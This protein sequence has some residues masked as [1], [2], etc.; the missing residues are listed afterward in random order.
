LLNHLEMIDVKPNDPHMPTQ[1]RSM[2][3][4]TMMM[5]T[6][7]YTQSYFNCLSY[8]SD[9]YTTCVST[10]HLFISVNWFPWKMKVCDKFNWPLIS[11]TWVFMCVFTKFS[12]SFIFVWRV[13]H[14]SKWPPLSFVFFLTKRQRIF[15][16]RLSN[17][18]TPPTNK[19]NQMESK[20]E[21]SRLRMH[22]GIF[23]HE[24]MR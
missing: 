23:A 21:K 19:T 9:E 13:A 11:G 10:G 17:Y 15:T 8:S 20:R 2:S 24:N 18:F 5:M 16:P 12:S 1:Q 7:N 4:T 3:T 14:T 6:L 22:D